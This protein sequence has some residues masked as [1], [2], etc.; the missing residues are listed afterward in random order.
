MK[1]IGKKLA[2][3]LAAVLALTAV[4]AGCSGG[5]DEEDKVIRV[6]V[7]PTPHGEIM[8]VV[9]EILADEGYDLEIVT[10]TD[11]VQPN[12]NLEEED[13]DANYFQHQQY[14][15]QFNEERGT[16]LVSVADVHYEPM[17]IYPGQSSSLEELPDGAT[18]AVPNDVTNEARALILLQDQGLITLDPEAGIEATPLD[19]TDNPK[20]LEFVEVESAQLPNVLQDVNLAVIN[21][22]YALQ[23]GLTISGDAIATEDPDSEIIQDYYVNV[24]VV[25]EGHEND[26]KIQAL[27]DALLSDTVRD[28]ITQTFTDGSVVPVF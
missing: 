14:L 5:G 12:L 27:K 4:L 3:L 17:G 2:V 19:I 9:K 26:E 10:F 7:N 16:H 24:L 6:G 22:N 15:D 23:G 28:F 1:K 21:G 18:I 25:R 11:Y 8:E 20:N 13:L